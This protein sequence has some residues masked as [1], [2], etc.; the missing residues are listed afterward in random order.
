MK[1]AQ[2]RSNLSG[3]LNLDNN[4]LRQVPKKIAA[5]SVYSIQIG[6]VWDY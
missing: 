3:S 5:P 2:F 4:K 1:I 6:T